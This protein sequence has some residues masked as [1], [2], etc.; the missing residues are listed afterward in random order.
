[1]KVAVVLFLLGLC[2]CSGTGFNP[3]SAQPLPTVSAISEECRGYI[4][5]EYQLKCEQVHVQKE[6]NKIL[7][8]LV[9]A[10][11]NK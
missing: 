11:K 10:L 2:G 6:Q 3:P 8:E 5:N 1:M 4:S 9:Q 7:A